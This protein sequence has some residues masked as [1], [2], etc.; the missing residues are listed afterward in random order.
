[1]EE[2]MLMY[3][4]SPYFS[5]NDSRDGGWYG[6]KPYGWYG[7]GYPNFYGYGYPYWYGGGHHHGHHGW[8]RDDEE[9]GRH[10]YSSKPMT[11]PCPMQ[12][13]VQPIQP[14]EKNYKEFKSLEQNVNLTEI[15]NTI[16]NIEQKHPYMMK[17]LLMM[18]IAY[19]ECKK[20]I[21]LALL[22]SGKF[23]L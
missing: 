14:I 5:E 11:I 21:Y 3:Q 9:N 23:G 22:C 7:Y 12:M 15:N 20:I 1:M 8:H 10:N 13:P 19:E 6:S 16:I 17:K 18:G 2:E 4:A